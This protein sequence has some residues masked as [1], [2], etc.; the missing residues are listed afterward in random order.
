MFL[1]M[2]ISESS[3]CYPLDFCSHFCSL[4]AQRVI[5]VPQDDS[6]DERSSGSDDSG[7]SIEGED[8]DDSSSDDNDSTVA[9]HAAA[10][11]LSPNP[12]G[13][14]NAATA[15]VGATAAVAA[16][17]GANVAPAGDLGV[18]LNVNGATSTSVSEPAP[19]SN[20]QD[21]P[22]KDDARDQK[23]F[24]EAGSHAEV[25]P[26]ID[27]DMTTGEGGPLVEAKKADTL[28]ARMD[29][30]SDM[31][32]EHD[33]NM[34]SEQETGTPR[35]S[36][37]IRAGTE[38]NKELKKQRKKLRKK[39]EEPTY[40]CPYDLNERDGDE[41]TPL[42]VAIH[43]RKLEHVKLLLV[44]G[45]SVHRKSDG[46]APIH[47]AISIG[48]VPMHAAF[49]YEC[50]MLL[51]EFN[52]DFSVKNDSVH[53]PLYL[54]CALNLPEVV[55]HILSDDVGLSTLNMRADRSGG[56]ALH[57]SAKFDSLS[58]AGYTG[59]SKM[60]AEQTRD[61]GAHHHPDGTIS[62]SGHHIP[63]SH[64]G[65]GKFG[66]KMIQAVGASSQSGPTAV[67]TH[68]LLSTPG[69]EID[70]QN[71]NGQ[72]PLH[73][74]CSRG[75]WSVV[76]LLLRSGASPNLKDRRGFT[77]GQ[78]ARKR[79]MPIPVDLLSALGD[80]LS[81][82]HG[83]PPRDLIVDPDSPTLLICHELCLLH[84]SCPPIR[85]DSAFEPPPEN[86]RRLHVLIN[87]DDG[88]LKGGEFGELVW[89]G[90]ARRASMVDVLKV[91]AC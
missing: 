59:G 81:S 31:P 21:S 6:D 75:N 9:A 57:A 83:A 34:V 62:H 10:I 90:K 51:G 46:S 26:I 8:D 64:D 84:R 88:I 4:F 18:D 24:K 28:T 38:A 19:K 1:A 40:Y 82:T 14:P 7:Q 29:T 67:I 71:S 41:N 44:A 56:R 42:H 76:R 80:T 48:A 49:A 66:G 68:I 89:E 77:P 27:S 36:V 43:A 45:A 55:S 2:I 22:A 61:V 85:R 11:G 5:F 39:R 13:I 63:G 35:I 50:T 15:P 25:S 32:V 79:G 72:T 16:G 23:K 69:I 87:G 60:T 30:C 70:A 78:L 33:A 3:C 52:A 37:V 54:A 58:S 53:T 47:T 74:A 17:M 12:P 65:P 91:R 20:E 86:I 73:V